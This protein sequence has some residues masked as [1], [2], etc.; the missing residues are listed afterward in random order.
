MFAFQHSCSLLFMGTSHW[1]LLWGRASVLRT[2]SWRMQT[3]SVPCV[4][5]YSFVRSRRQNLPS[6]VRAVASAE[7]TTFSEC[8]VTQSFKKKK[9]PK[10]SVTL[11][12]GRP[13]DPFQDLQKTARNKPHSAPAN[14]VHWE[15]TSELS[16]QPSREFWT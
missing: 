12:K 3:S 16:L 8:T 1:E 10:S 5:A 7:S 4:N 6:S 11:R 14:Q 2:S 13:R 15:R 9:P